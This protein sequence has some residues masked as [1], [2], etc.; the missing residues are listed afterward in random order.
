MTLVAGAYDVSLDIGGDPNPNAKKRS[1]LDICKAVLK[2]FPGVTLDEIR[3]SHRFRH[4]V[5]ARQACMYEIYKER[6]DVSFPMLGHFFGG[7]DHSTALHAVK[8][9]AAQRGDP[10]AAKWVTR[11]HQQVNASHERCKAREQG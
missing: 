8:R 4:V 5:E 9:V 2:N 11:K 1:M 3:G 10:D 7:R 6:K